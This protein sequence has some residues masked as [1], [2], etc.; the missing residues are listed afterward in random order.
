MAPQEKPLITRP[1]A[2]PAGPRRMGWLLLALTVLLPSAW[3]LK[4]TDHFGLKELEA[5]PNLAP[6]NFANLFEDFAYDYYP[7]LQSPSTF[8]Q[9]RSGDCDDY[10]ILAA[11]ILGLRGF[12]TRLIRVEL[13]GTRINHVVC[14][15]TDKKA[16]LDYNNRKYSINLEH[17]GTSIRAIA[18]NVADSF[19]K[20]WTTGT[21][22][23]YS[24]VEGRQRTVCIV[25]KT[26]PPA[27]DP[28]RRPA[29]SAH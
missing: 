6:G 20:N 24:Y 5:E 14:Y 15:V 28:D 25:V 3:A 29:P 8:L 26:D 1:S 7:Y 9:N 12:K 16:Y 22:Y 27:R 19:A 2:A 4:P 21:E 18:D 23:T 13:V 11:H 17:S 10:A